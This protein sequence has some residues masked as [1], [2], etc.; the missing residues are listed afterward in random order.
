[1]APVEI[2]GH[3]IGAV[4]VLLFFISYQVKEKKQL[5][6]MQTIATALI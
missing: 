2:T 6:L 5:L 3:I 4:G 1:M